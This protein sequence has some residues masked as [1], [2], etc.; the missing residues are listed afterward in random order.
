MCLCML[1]YVCVCVC[2]RAR[3]CVCACMRLAVPRK[4]AD[5]AWHEK[6]GRKRGTA[7]LK[8]LSSA[9]LSH[10]SSSIDPSW[11]NRIVIPILSRTSIVLP[12]LSLGSHTASKTPL[13]VCLPVMLIMDPE[14]GLTPPDTGRSLLPALPIAFNLPPL[15]PLSGLPIGAR[16]PLWG[17]PIGSKL[18]LFGLITGSKLP[19]FG[20][21]NPGMFP[22]RGRRAVVRSKDPDKDDA[23]PIPW[24][25]SDSAR[26]MVSRLPEAE[27]TE[28]P[29]GGRRMPVCCCRLPAVAG[30]C[31]PKDV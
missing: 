30:L 31:C 25:D 19:L 5:K 11:S 27:A 17:L 16:F 23:G 21:P 3:A 15:F 28:R 1:L 13:G 26:D 7:G 14:P 24:P 4:P 18:P 8:N 20:L 22:D 10:Q 6:R 9:R 29:E 12:I 2:V